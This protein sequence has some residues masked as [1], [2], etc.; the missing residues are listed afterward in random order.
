MEITDK[1]NYCIILAGGRGRR[2]WPVSREQHPKQFV[3]LFGTGRSQLQTTFDR[4]ARLLPKE[5]I[6]ICTCQEFVGLVKEQLPEVDRKSTRLNSSHI[7]SS[8]MPSSA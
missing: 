5:N 1:K 7:R 3:D 2:L 4:F 6:F 8:R